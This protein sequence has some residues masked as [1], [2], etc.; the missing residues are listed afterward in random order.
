M[1]QLTAT[2]TVTIKTKPDGDYYFDHDDLV[3]NVVPWIEGG[4]DDRDD[5]A[6]VTITEQPAAVSAA[7]A[8][9][10]QAELRQ[11]IAEALLDHLSR[12]ADIRPGR[13]GEQAFMP[14][15]TDAERM[16]MAAAVLAVLP[17]PTDRAEWDAL[18][19]ETDRLRKAWGE[20]RDRAERIEAEVERLTAD[21]AAVLREAADAVAAH[22]GPIPWLPGLPKG[23]G[24]G[25]WW[26]TRDR[27]AAADLLRRMAD[28]TAT[29]ETHARPAGDPDCEHCDG[30]GLDPDA[31]FVNEERSVWTHA[32]CSA[33]LPD[34][35]DD[36]VPTIE[37]V[38]HSG[39]DTA[40][41]VLCLSGEHE[42][43][44][45]PAAGARQD[46]TAAD[47][48]ERCAHCTHPKRDHDGRAD[49]RAKH[50]PLVAGDPWCHACNAQCDY[51]AG[52]RQ[53]EPVVTVHAV[54]MPGSNGIS[55]CC[56]RPPCEFVGERVT[57]DPD[58]VTCPGPAA[59][60]GQDG[61]TP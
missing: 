13:D 19:R 61:A 59:G 15:V 20:M 27:D 2:F 52:A 5:I 11:R 47:E 4:L 24:E 45:E 50:S 43:V 55:A 30:S 3:R 40:F 44:D 57:R 39:P 28:E 51:A 23:E 12:T 60:A 54:P 1:T 36:P 32:P 29:T 31:Y 42:R 17:E 34:D 16:R 33:C 49:R 7:V 58:K 21:R 26:D 53:D 18:C 14:E 22:P 48:P 35:E 9:P 41:C 25:F 37:R 6:E 56:G 8:P 10:A 38:K 46:E